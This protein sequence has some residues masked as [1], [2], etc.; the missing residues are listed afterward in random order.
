MENNK[1]NRFYS[2]KLVSELLQQFLMHKIT[3]SGIDKVWHDAL[4]IHLN[5]RN[6]TQEER[7][8]LIKITET[9]AEVLKNE[10]QDYLIKI[11][12]KNRIENEISIADLKL[13]EINKA[14][15]SL[16]RIAYFGIYLIV[17][18]VIAIFI[19]FASKDLDTIRYAYIL[20]GT[21]SFL[22]YLLILN[23]LYEAGENLENFTL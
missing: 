8:L 15:K 4:I 23:S 16:K 10:Q 11:Q 7:N 19:S 3:G 20:L 6:L 9:P 1:Y 12:G 17:L 21:V 18:T 22:F 14:G 13:S 5:E 2:K